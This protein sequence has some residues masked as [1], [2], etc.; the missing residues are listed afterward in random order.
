MLT[1]KIPLAEALIGLVLCA[2]SAQAQEI[3]GVVA[4][5]T[6]LPNVAADQLH[7]RAES[8]YGVPGK[9]RAAA[10]LHEREASLRGA[11]D[12]RGIDALDRAARLYAYAGNRARARGLMQKAG[13]RA[14][15]AGEVRRA[16]HAYIDAAFLALADR[17]VVRAYSL[18]KRADLLAHSPHLDSADRAGIVR[19]ID[20]ARAQMGM[21]D[22]P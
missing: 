4:P 19:R 15:R 20:P 18:T 7:A 14:L 21:L 1:K 22:H 16:A 3:R 9:L 5:V 13:D 6:E 8:L 12:L 11:A 10:S 2:A 17:D